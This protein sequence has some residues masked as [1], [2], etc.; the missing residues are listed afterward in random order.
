MI[1]AEENNVLQY[2]YNFMGPVKHIL[3]HKTL[4]SSSGWV[5]H[6]LYF[7]SNYL[8]E[9]L[10]WV[11]TLSYLYITFPKTIIHVVKSTVISHIFFVVCLKTILTKRPLDQIYS[12]W[13]SCNKRNTSPFMRSTI[14][15]FIMCGKMRHEHESC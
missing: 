8:S 13:Q 4:Q 5:F 9:N 3:G 10:T 2:K 7:I 12:M 15:G 6:Y 1:H 14:Y 11:T